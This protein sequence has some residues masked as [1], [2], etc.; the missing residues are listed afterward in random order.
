MTAADTVDLSTPRSVL[1]VGVGGPGMSAIAVVL[2][3]MGHRVRGVDVHETPFLEHVRACGVEVVLGHRSSNLDGMELACISTA[4][5][6]GNADVATA[7]ERGIPLFRRGP[8]L[9]AICRQTRAVG[10]AGTHGKTSTASM[11]AVTLQHGGLEPGFIIGG[12]LHQLGIGAR[13]GAGSLLVIEA[14]ESDGTFLD[15]PLQGSV[16]TNIEV[17]HLDHFGT[18]EAMY[19]GFTQYLAACGAPTVVCADDPMVAALSGLGTGRA[20]APRQVVSYGTAQS[21]DYRMIDRT[22]LRNGAQ[23][24]AVLD[25]RHAS[26]HRLASLELPVRGI[27]MA[28]NALGAL[29]MALELGVDVESAQ[30]ALAGYRGVA[31]RFDIRSQAHGI[32]LVDDYAHLPTEIAAVLAAAAGSGDGWERVVAVFQPNRYS[33][34]AVLSGDYRDCFVDADVVV[35]ADIYPSGEQPLPGVTGALVADAV[36][37]AHPGADVSFC[38]DRAALATVVASRLRSGDVCISMGCGDVADLPDEIGALLR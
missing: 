3:E 26:P 24:F 38:A 25:Q 31:R 36:R 2:R 22:V 27:H 7:R 32:T 14:D 19:D 11:L 30:R 34:M 10:V 18:V 12:Q 15:L 8:V 28:R 5:R 35:V 9:A 21:A 17:D 33:R 4:I 13:W 29:A 16:L 23:S 6:D 1:V 37:A 20:G